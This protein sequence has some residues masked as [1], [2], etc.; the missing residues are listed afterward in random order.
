MENICS[1]FLISSFCKWSCTTY[2][3]SQKIHFQTL[4]LVCNFSCGK[5]NKNIHILCPNNK[6][7]TDIVLYNFILSFFPWFVP[8]VLCM[9]PRTSETLIAS[10]WQSC[11]V[12]FPILIAQTWIVNI[13]DFFQYQS[14][15]YSFQSV[16]FPPG[17]H[18][19]LFHYSKNH[20][21]AYMIQAV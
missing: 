8:K 6:T 5:E 15:K 18:D 14:L 3:S 19:F 20:M 7:G 2:C 4:N 13:G 21:I 1:S 16:Y 17:I 12:S 11:S 10:Y 9:I